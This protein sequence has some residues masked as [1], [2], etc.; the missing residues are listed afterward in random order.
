MLSVPQV[1]Q[2]LKRIQCTHETPSLRYLR[3]LHR[4]HLYHIPFEN[5][6]N[7]LGFQI[8]L[9]VQKIYHKVMERKRGGFCYE[10]NGL[11]HQL[12]LALGFDAKLI[13]CQVY[14]SSGKLGPE[15]DHM[16]IIVQ[17]TE[18][19]Y[20]VDV[21]FGEFFRSPLVIKEG[22][23]QMDFQTYYQ[24]SKNIDDVYVV[25][26]SKDTIEYSNQYEF[27]N[28]ARS[29]IE[30][31]DM[32]QFH[33]KNP[34]SHLVKRLYVHQSKSNG[35]LVITNTQLTIELDGKTEKVPIHNKDDFEAKLSQHFGLDFKRNL[36]R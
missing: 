16:A 1:G 7:F 22:L 34:E 12:L 30:F 28:E 21:G 6:D 20:L 14:H 31:V 26:Q 25:K 36:K 10:L 19:E 18:V 35:Q 27:K 23:V 2:Y 32:C 17:L 15:F 3:T 29:L 24:I 13:A 8:L 4:Q 5:L 33:H 11:F 9:D